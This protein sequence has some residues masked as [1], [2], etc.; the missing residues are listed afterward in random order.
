MRNERSHRRRACLLGFATLIAFPAR[1]AAETLR[2]P[3]PRPRPAPTAA[4]RVRTPARDTR[5]QA[6]AAGRAVS[7][8]AQ[9][10]P[11]IDGPP[12]PSRRPGWDA[13]PVPNGN[14]LPPIGERQ[15]APSVSFGVPS[16]PV[17][18][19]GQTFRGSDPAPQVRQQQGGGLRLPSPGAT[20]RLPF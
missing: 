7:P 11:Q 9:P 3:R 18:I 5:K 19:E 20:V 1:A 6:V 12:P 16:P 14:V 10:L 8:P 13:A 2:R 4:P 15:V 17:L